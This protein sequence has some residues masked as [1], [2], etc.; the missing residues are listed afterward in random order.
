MVADLTGRPVSIMEYGIDESLH[1]LPEHEMSAGDRALA[2]HDGMC[3]LCFHAPCRCLY[4]GAV[5]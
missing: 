4:R 5:K 2:E 1:C 3:Y